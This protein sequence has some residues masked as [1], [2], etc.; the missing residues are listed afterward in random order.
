MNLH[1]NTLCRG[2]ILS[3]LVAA[4]GATGAGCASDRA[5]IGQA[6]QAHSS[7]A[8]AVIEYPVLSG[9]IQG[10]KG[11]GG[12]GGGLGTGL[13]PFWGLRG[14]GG[15]DPRVRVPGPR[16]RGGRGGV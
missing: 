4:L 11:G 6:N 14:K 2:I 15:K 12:G 1:L 5:V 9:Y 7:I 10:V 13:R 8:P 3:V 16:R